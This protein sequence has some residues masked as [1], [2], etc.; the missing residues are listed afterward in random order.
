MKCLYT[1]EE[2]EHIENEFQQVQGQYEFLLHN[3]VWRNFQNEKA[4][5][6]AKH[7]FSRR[8]KT[9]VRC[10][11]RLFELL[12]PNRVD[13]PDDDDL[14]DSAIFVQAFIFNVF[15]VIDN[16]ASIWVSETGLTERNGKQ[17]SRKAVG[18]L[19]GCTTLRKSLSDDLQQYLTSLD[20]W[21]SYLASY[22]HALAHRVP[23]YIPPSV[24]IGDKR[25]LFTEIGRKI[26]EAA[27]RGDVRSY[28]EL[29][30]EQE[31]L[32]V[33]RPWMCHSFNEGADPVA[34]HPQMLADFNTVCE[35]GK[36]MLHEFDC[37]QAR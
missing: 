16:L 23:L 2:L 19:P 25:T 5:E 36:R 11:K 33:F 26:E 30:K 37:K 10:I 13:L 24:V 3:Y 18:L 14:T 27:K 28:K 22:R 15:G 17:L 29:F 35:I 31:A 4:I 12:P 9:L 1:D 6:Y 21:F 7:G 32:G 8:M 20:G 34:V